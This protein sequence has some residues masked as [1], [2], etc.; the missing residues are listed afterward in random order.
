MIDNV[1]AASANLVTHHR[2]QHNPGGPEL[3]LIATAVKQHA[4]RERHQKITAR[5]HH[6]NREQQEDPTTRE[7]HAAR[8]QPEALEKSGGTEPKNKVKLLHTKLT[9]KEIPPPATT[10]LTNNRRRTRK[11]PHKLGTALTS[12]LHDALTQRK[13]L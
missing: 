4:A 12:H 11:P 13:A 6:A 1:I 5:E 10:P 8:E 9:K 2:L 3:K 7:Q